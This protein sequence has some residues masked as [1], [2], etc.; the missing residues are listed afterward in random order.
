MKN[1]KAKNLLIRSVTIL[2]G[3]CFL[4]F[5]LF[6]YFSDDIN[7]ISFFLGKKEQ[8]GSLF[9]QSVG[10]YTSE[11]YRANLAKEE[12]DSHFTLEFGLFS[13]IDQA[14]SLIDSL[15]EKKI[16]AYYRLVLTEDGDSMYMVVR[17]GVFNDK[18][19]A[20]KVADKLKF[21]KKIKTQ[22]V[23]F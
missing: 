7:P 9:Y 1:L 6:W 22:V 3:Y 10:S 16:A 8:Q 12:D 23:S 17:Q 5:L 19:E 18:L 14:R 11:Q 21:S 15:A 13:E 20:Q 4:T 2:F